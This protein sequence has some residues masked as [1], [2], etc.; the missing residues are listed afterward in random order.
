LLI[1]SRSLPSE[2]RELPR[3]RRS[4]IALAEKRHEEAVR[5]MRAAADAEDASDK[6]P[7]TPGNVAPSRELLGEML[8]TLNYPAQAFTEVNITDSNTS[9]NTTCVTCQ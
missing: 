4:A 9:K 2:G 7:V 6:H 1:N 5:L 8:I 3:S